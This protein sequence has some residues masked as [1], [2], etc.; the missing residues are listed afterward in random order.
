MTQIS[1]IHKKGNYLLIGNSRL[2]W[3]VKRNETWE[4]THTSKKEINIEF[5]KMPLSAWAAVGA[6]PKNMSLDPSL[7]ITLK[8][9]PLLELPP[10]LGIDRA[11]GS[12]AAY[13]KAKASLNLHSN[14][15]LIADAGTVLSLTKIS[16]KGEFEGGQLSAGLHLQLKAMSEDTK[17]LSYTSIDSIPNSLFPRSTKDK[18][19]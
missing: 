6:I 19:L 14:G 18:S 9:I 17:N 16:A 12:W 8:D 15:I 5:L 3:A 1:N 2:H 7:E 11:L 4:F 13:K 10:W